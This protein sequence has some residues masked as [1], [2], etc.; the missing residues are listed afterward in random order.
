[1]PRPA[2]SFRD[3]AGSCCVLEHNVLRFVD[4]RNIAEFEGFLK[5]RVARDCVERKDLVSTRRLTDAE[6]EALAAS[7]ALTSHSCRSP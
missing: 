2:L 5:T 7:S 6:V 1:M 4:P 3:P